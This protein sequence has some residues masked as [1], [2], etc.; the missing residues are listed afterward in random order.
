MT[1]NTHIQAYP[2][3]NAYDIWMYDVYVAASSFLQI[4]ILNSK[5]HSF[6]TTLNEIS[7][8]YST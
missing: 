8:S 2:R 3:T 6:E 5:P 7:F 1:R 4:D